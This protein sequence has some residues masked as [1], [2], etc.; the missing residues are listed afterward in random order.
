MIWLQAGDDPV[1]VGLVHGQVRAADDQFNGSGRAEAHDL[2]DH[3]GRLEREA[4]TGLA[5]SA[6][7]GR[8]TPYLFEPRHQPGI[9]LFG[10]FLAQLVLQIGDADAAV[11]LEG[12]PHDALVGAAAPEVD[13]VDGQRGGGDA[14]VGHRDVDVDLG[15]S[16]WVAA[17]SLI[18]P[19]SCLVMSSLTSRYEPTGEWMRIWNCPESTVGAI[20]RPT[21]VPKTRITRSATVR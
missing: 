9:D 5:R 20:S 11:L 15:P 12:D 2:V 19:A 10:Q 21:C 7:S 8:V 13:R 6:A 17:A 14:D 3:V 4:S 16:F 1:G 18:S